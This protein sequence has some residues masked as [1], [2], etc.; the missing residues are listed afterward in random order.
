MTPGLT[1]ICIALSTNWETT[2][3]LHTIL[4][5]YRSISG[6]SGDPNWTDFGDICGQTFIFEATNLINVS[7]IIWDMGNSQTISDTNVFNYT[8]PAYD[9]YYP[10]ATLIDSLGCEVIYP[11]DSLEVLSNGLDAYFEPTPS[12]GPMGSTFIL[13]DYSIF[14]TSPIVFWEWQFYNDTIVNPNGSSVIQPYGL[15][16]IYPITLVVTDANGCFDTYYSSV[17][18]TDDFHLPNV[19]TANEDGVNDEFVLPVALFESFDIVI[20]NRWGNVIHEHRGATGT[21]LW[22]GK[23]QGGVPVTDGTY[24]Y[25]LVGTVVNGEQASKEGFVQVFH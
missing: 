4:V 6:P 5:D 25:K 18:V 1:S 20:I 3:K 21:L 12:E 24:F 10:T 14:T 16:G 11:L 13:D 2:K 7:E 23:T 15:P 17:E 19:I 9:T 8:Y 22:D